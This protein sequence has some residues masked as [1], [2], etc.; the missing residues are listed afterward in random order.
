MERFL[1]I[2]T[3]RRS[4]RRFENRQVDED[5]LTHILEA[6]RWTPS[7]ANSQCWEVIVVKEPELKAEISTLLSPKNPATLVVA[8]APITLALCAAIQKSG[9]YKGEPSTKFGDWLM[10]DMGLLTQTICLTAHNLG[11]G[12][13]I[14][15][16]FQHDK[17]KS[18]LQLPDGYEV[19]T[20]LPLG[21]PDHAPSGPKRREVKEFVH[22]DR[23]GNKKI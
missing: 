18:L 7:W 2:V 21:Y 20:L 22:R 13:V 23:F 1:D 3:G 12:T 5:K 16:A 6:S 17:V 19:V 15:G 9:Y 10:Y 8:H 4:I 11:L 14:V